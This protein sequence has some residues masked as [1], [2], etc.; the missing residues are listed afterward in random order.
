MRFCRGKSYSIE[1]VAREI[2]GYP[3]F[4]DELLAG[5]R[6]LFLQVGNLRPNLDIQVRPRL[7]TFG[8]TDTLHRTKLGLATNSDGPDAALV[9]EKFGHDGAG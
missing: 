1:P 3:E 8:P 4:S 2:R 7:G 9:L 6:R 5:N